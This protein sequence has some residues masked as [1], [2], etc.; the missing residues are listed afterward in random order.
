MFYA[1]TLKFLHCVCVYVC[2]CV[3]VYVCVCVCV[4]V[5]LCVCVC[6]YVCVFARTRARASHRK[7]T[8]WSFSSQVSMMPCGHSCIFIGQFS[9]CT[10]VTSELGLAGTLRSRV[11]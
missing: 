8:I 3:C 5:C 11:L 10:M 1:N 2:V 7:S 4:C 6:V 9:Y